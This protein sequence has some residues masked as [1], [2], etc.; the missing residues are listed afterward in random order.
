[1]KKINKLL[2][3]ILATV[4]VMG[5]SSTKKDEEKAIEFLNAYYSQYA[6]KSD[7]EK[8]SNSDNLSSADIDSYILQYFDN[9]LTGKAKDTLAAN[10]LVPNWNVLHSDIIEAKVSDIKFEKAENEVEG[11]LAFSAAINNKH[12]DG[13]VSEEIAEGLIK[14][15]NENGKYKVDT[16]RLIAK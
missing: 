9:M 4:M 7:L 2:T 6:N 12:V 8:L 13:K 16:F 15:I 10:R 5:C 11:T 14:V 3:V 1:M